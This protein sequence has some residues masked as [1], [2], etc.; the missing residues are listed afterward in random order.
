MLRAALVLSAVLAL[1]LPAGAGAASP[2]CDVVAS[3]SGDD[4]A[5]GTADAP[6]RT[7]RRA[8]ELLE[9][10]EA[11]CLTAGETFHE[12]VNVNP[13]GTAAAP[14]TLRSTPGGRAAFTGQI[15]VRGSHIRIAGIDFRG[16]AAVAS[17]APKTYH[18]GVD[19][20]DVVLSDLEITNP[21]GICVDVGQVD[22]FGGTPGERADGFVLERS[23]VHHCGVTAKVTR[24]DSGVHGIYLKHTSGAR[25]ADLFVH[26]NLN[27]GIQLWPAAAGTLVER[28]TLE[29]NGSNLNLGSYPAQGFYSTGTL[30]RRSVIANSRLRS[31]GSCDVPPGD[32]AN[33]VGNFPPGDDDHGNRI[34]DNCVFQSDPGRNFEGYGFRQSGNRFERPA[35][36]DRAAGDLRPAEGSPCAGYGASGPVPAAGEPPAPPTEPAPPTATPVPTP[37]PEPQPPEMPVDP[38]PVAEAGVIP[39]VAPAPSARRPRLLV[40]AVRTRRGVRARILAPRPGRVRLRVTAG[41]R[42]LATR[43]VTLRRRART[44]TL[45]VRPT[46]RALR[47]TATLRG[48]RS[49]TVRVG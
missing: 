14:L 36:V 27:R 39:M 49:A 25:L 23:R 11:A 13:S 5:A 26:D 38:E 24:E 46:R 19:G 47:L 18:L 22:A 33:V 32:T 37:S 42:T 35:Y 48:A 12:L 7:V 40:V 3:L 17:F 20:D 28:V 41:R 29:G 34:E 31:C 4:S 2:A 44:V 21:P 45:R 16:L 30:V 15:R 9:P 8:V 10:G 1:A 6:V 43:T